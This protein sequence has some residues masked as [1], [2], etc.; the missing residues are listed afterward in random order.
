MQN[1]V[2]TLAGKMITLSPLKQLEDG[3][4]LTMAP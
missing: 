3:G 2:K 4:T 1:F